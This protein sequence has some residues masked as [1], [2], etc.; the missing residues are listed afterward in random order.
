MDAVTTAIVAAVLSGAH[1]QLREAPPDAAESGADAVSRSY[2]TLKEALVE[3]F[4]GAPSLMAAIGQLEGQDN[5][6]NRQ[7]LHQEVKIVR[8]DQA[9]HVVMAADALLQALQ[10]QPG[11]K[12][13]LL[14]ARTWERLA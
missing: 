2:Q 8:A 5:A 14:Q 12:E 10:E 9:R 7:K 3:R 11:G 13:L 1:N 4:E 6:R